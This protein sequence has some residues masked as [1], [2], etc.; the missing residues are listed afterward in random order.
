MHDFIAAFRVPLFIAT[1]L[2][3]VAL[4]AIVADANAAGSQSDDVFWTL[5][6][7]RV[8][9]TP[10]TPAELEYTEIEI[11]RG[12]LLVRTER[13]PAPGTTLNVTRT[14]PPNYELCYSAR[15]KALE[16]DAPSEWTPLVCKTVKA[17]PQPPGQLD[18]K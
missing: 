7:Q 2:V 5:P 16:P 3:L 1:L 4:L 12:E 10:L 8:D 17:R 13:V 14:L 11:W 6:T 15:V 9:G 18:V